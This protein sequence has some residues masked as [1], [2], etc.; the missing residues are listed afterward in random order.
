NTLSPAP[1]AAVRTPAA[2]A[3]TRGSG[4]I[5]PGA[6]TASVSADRT[7]LIAATEVGTRSSHRCRDAS[8][9]AANINAYCGRKDGVGRPTTGQGGQTGTVS[10]Q[11]A[12]VAAM[13]AI[14]ARSGTTATPGRSADA[15]SRTGQRV[16]RAAR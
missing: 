5:I 12:P 14:S 8:T 7:A 6:S 15:A 11:A 10:R 9:P 2:T 1:S 4:D 13:T 16:P 3:E